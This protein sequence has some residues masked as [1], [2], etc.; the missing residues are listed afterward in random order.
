MSS[1]IAADTDVAALL[2]RLG[3]PVYAHHVRQ[4]R[5]ACRRRVRGLPR[6]AARRTHLHRRRHRARRRRDALGSAGIQLGSTPGGLPHLP[7]EHLKA[8]LGA[9]ADFVYGHPSRDLWMVGVTGTNGK[10][11]CAHW[12]AAGLQSTGRRTAVLGTLGNGLIGASIRP[13]A[14]TTPDAAALHEMLAAVQARRRRRGRDG[15]LVARHRPGPR[16][17]REFRG[18]A[19]HQPVARSPRLPRDDGRVRRG[20]GATVHAGPACA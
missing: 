16:Q 15:S 7:L 20:E 1:A 11:S 13:T 19:V 17:R 9:I 3:H 2:K 18:G 12:I 14:N 4:P 6:D 8:R 10:T 5:R